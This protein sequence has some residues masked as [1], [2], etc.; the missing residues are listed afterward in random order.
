MKKKINKNNKNALF[1]IN[2][3]FINVYNNAK[4]TE[5]N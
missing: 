3:N 1:F 5:N 4:L 2:N